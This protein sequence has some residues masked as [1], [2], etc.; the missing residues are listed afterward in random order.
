MRAPHRR[1][2]VSRALASGALVVIVACASPEPRV[3]ARPP[4]E[5]KP[6]VQKSVA[7]ASTRPSTTVA[8]DR[9]LVVG[10]ERA[11]NREFLGIAYAAPPVGNRRWKRPEPAPAWTTPRDATRRGRA[12]P[13]PNTWGMVRDTSEDCLTLNVWVPAGAD[14]KLPVLFWI[15]GGAF[16]QGSGGDDFHDGA[17]LATVARAVVVTIN[18]RLGALGFMAHRELAHEASVA[19]SPSFGFLDQRAALSWV[20]TNIGAFGGDPARVTVFGESAGA[21]S[22]C[23]HIASPGSRG[24]FS[25]AVMQSGACSNAFY[26]DAK[27]A[28]AQ[29][30]ALADAV[31]CKGPGVLSCLRAKS[32][33]A[34]ISALP[35]KRASLLPPGV[36][37]GLT[38]D[39]V[40]LAR[41]PLESLRMGDFARV[42]LVIGWNRD[43]G[44]LHTVSFPSVEPS[45]RDGFVRDVFGEA[46]VR[47]VPERYAKASPKQSLTDIVTDGVF[48]CQARRV[49]RVLA[50]QDVPVFLYEWA[51][52]LDHPVAH[53]VGATHGVEL[54][55]LW[56]NPGMG[57]GLSDE[58]LALSRTMMQAWGR[59]A[60]TGNPNGN[61]LVWPRYSIERDEHLTFDLVPAR[62]A[63]LKREACDFWDDIE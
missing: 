9:G 62:G 46:A 26:F 59:F 56:G 3:V 36:W 31:G 40:E 52:A 48:A 53:R 50:K 38:I 4:S 21:W 13:Q 2:T 14:E 15:H 58:E 12:C 39:G 23:S 60:H 55:F 22:V 45:E 11:G 27:E 32:V 47:R 16:F 41:R 57:I 19:V 8:T 33:D 54:F 30:T 5:S 20:Q 28:E 1:T 42:P 37:W 24:L 35:L 63:N 6:A 43:E 18:Y 7:K 10:S 17:K 25:R 51:R 49:A 44:I 34:V 61:G 29:G